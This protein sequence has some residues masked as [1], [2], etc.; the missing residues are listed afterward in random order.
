[1]SFSKLKALQFNFYAALCFAVASGWVADK[2][3]WEALDQHKLKLSAYIV[4][5]KGG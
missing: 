3:D 1:M 2:G 4:Y 5:P